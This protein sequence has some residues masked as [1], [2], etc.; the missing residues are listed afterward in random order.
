M[1]PRLSSALVVAAPLSL[2]L[3]A[4]QF[5]LIGRVSVFPE[6]EWFAQSGGLP[7]AQLLTS[8]NLLPLLLGALPA[9]VTA[10]LVTRA[11]IAVLRRHSFAL[12]ST[13]QLLL[14]WALVWLAC[15]VAL[16]LL[17]AG[18]NLSNW[19][20]GFFRQPAVWYG[21]ILTSIGLHLGSRARSGA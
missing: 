6:S 9:G 2:L 13:A 8:L 5:W 20:L 10:Y 16:Y 21:L 17:F 7:F 12:P 3:F 19:S 18:S 15:W 4:L 1:N 14:V 11:L